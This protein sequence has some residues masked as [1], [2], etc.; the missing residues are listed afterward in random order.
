MDWEDDEG[1]LS[2][3]LVR[4]IDSQAGIETLPE[5]CLQ[6]VEISPGLHAPVFARMLRQLIQSQGTL[7][8]QLIT[9]KINDSNNDSSILA[10]ALEVVEIDPLPE[11]IDEL[12]GSF[13]QRNLASPVSSFIKSSVKSMQPLNLAEEFA[14]VAVSPKER[15]HIMSLAKI[16]SDL[17][18]NQQISNILKK[19][20]VLV[21]MGCVDDLSEE[22]RFLFRCL[23]KLELAHHSNLD[24]TG[25]LH[26]LTCAS[27][28]VKCTTSHWSIF[29]GAIVNNMDSCLASFGPCIQSLLVKFQVIRFHGGQF[30]RKTLAKLSSL[31]RLNPSASNETDDNNAIIGFSIPFQKTIDSRHN[32][33]TKELTRLYSN[34]EAVRDSFLGA[35]RAFRESR[36]K[37]KGSLENAGGNKPHVEELVSDCMKLL[38]APNIYWFAQL[39]ASELIQICSAPATESDERVTELEKDKNKLSRLQRRFSAAPASQSI[40]FEKPVCKTDKPVLIPRS[41]KASEWKRIKLTTPEPKTKK[42]EPEQDVSFENHPYEQGLFQD[43][44]AF[45]HLFI[46]TCDSHR[47][48]S[49]LQAVIKSK[50]IKLNDYQEICKS[51][52]GP[53]ESFCRRLVA[54]RLLGK[55]L[56]YLQFSPNWFSDHEAY[57][58]D[59]LS[60]IQDIIPLSQSFDIDEI[61]GAAQKLGTLCFTLPWVCSYL[62]M[63]KPDRISRST[64]ENIAWMN[65]L[66][67]LHSLLDRNRSE[68]L[69][70]VTELDFLLSTLDLYPEP[71]I[72]GPSALIH[73]IPAEVLMSDQ[74]IQR[75][76]NAA[77]SLRSQLA[78]ALS[79]AI[80][81]TK[82]DGSKTESAQ[83]QSAPIRK[84]RPKHDDENRATLQSDS[85]DKQLVTAFLHQNPELSKIIDFC[86][87]VLTDSFLEQIADGDI[88]KTIIKLAVDESVAR[89][90]VEAVAIHKATTAIIHILPEKLTFQ[91]TQ[92]LKACCPLDTHQGV[93]NAALEAA[94]LLAKKRAKYT[95]PSKLP[96]LISAELRNNFTKSKHTVQ[97]LRDDLMNMEAMNK[98][99]LK[100]EPPFPGVQKYSSDMMQCIAR[101][102]FAPFEN[103]FLIIQNL[104]ILEKMYSAETCISVCLELVLQCKEESNSSSVELMITAIGSFASSNQ[105]LLL[106]EHLT[107]LSVFNTCVIYI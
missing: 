75:C 50:L 78:K 102:D 12:P 97:G 24:F 15:R 49:I 55:F 71:L 5:L 42:V 104:G 13:G 98:M 9:D 40:G 58:D 1:M 6:N 103:E 57:A 72:V 70:L 96:S 107:E 44:E 2:V 45:F 77:E 32:F 14:K 23:E 53:P 8:I 84:I 22:M 29:I 87:Q 99:L 64:A 91:F 26:K 101:R 63:T 17:F 79:L 105:H 34:R 100:L 36:N 83:K 56:G 51:A 43:D 73:V 68:D 28:P 19:Y 25:I 93:I 106:H 52:S 30:Y 10:D 65:H 38:V 54:A 95:L 67:S 62:V 59:S 31:P 7:L 80:G 11:P 81:V 16:V 89:D 18:G 27:F 76:W 82:T 66:I 90:S 37:L 47:L 86:S 46:A 21:C 88:G 41:K 60:V 33:K 20:S 48:N 39:F 4:L 94:L 85:L 61:L 74:F 3:L 92:V 69:F 35:I